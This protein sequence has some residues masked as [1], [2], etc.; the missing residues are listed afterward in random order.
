MRRRALLALM[1][2]AAVSRLSS[3]VAAPRTARIGYLAPIIGRNE[4]TDIFEQ[5]LQKLGWKIGDN[6]QVEYWYTGGRQDT[7]QPLAEQAVA[8]NLDALIV[9]GPPLALAVK[10]LTNH[11]PIVFLITFDPVEV[12]LVPSLS[13]PGGNLTGVTS[14]ASLDIISKRLQILKEVLPSMSHVG[15]LVS[16]EQT[17][18]AGGRDALTTAARTLGLGLD[19]IPVVTPADLGG[20]MKAAKEKGVQAVYVWPSGFTFSFVKEIAIATTEAGLPS[21]H[22]FREGALAGGLLAYAADLREEVRSGAAYIDKILKGTPPANLPVEQMS[23]YQLV[24]NLKTAQ[25]LGLTIPPGTMLAADEV[26]E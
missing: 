15:V 19:D 23:K 9:W 11:I 4:I 13:H 3:T 26:I 16:T 14:L 6:I 12:G 22:S 8:A 2:T 21:I 18:T 24:A 10:K 25:A 17:R 20:A 1:I 5:S 7:V